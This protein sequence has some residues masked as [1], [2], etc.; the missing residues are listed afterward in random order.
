M[1]ADL[2]AAP[3]AAARP[4]LPRSWPVWVASLLAMAL[5][6]AVPRPAAAQS[7]VPVLPRKAALGAQLSELQ[8]GVRIDAVVPNLTA[9]ALGLQVGDV[10]NRLNDTTVRTPAEVAAW[11]STQV[12][13]APVRVTG[14]RNRKPL[15][16]SGTLAGRT[17]EVST[18]HQ[19][20]YGQV[21]S[22][23]GWLR[24]IVTAPNAGAAQKHPALMFVQ[25]IGPGTV[26]FALTAD[27]GYAKVIQP[28]ARSGYV[29]MRVDKPGVGDSEGGPFAAVDFQQT[30]DGYRQALKA[31][32]A[33]P[34]VDPER[35]F[36][37]GH[38]MG[39]YWG[40][41]L[42]REFKLKGIVVS[43][44]AFRTWIEY[45]LENTRRQG[46]LGGTTPLDMHNLLQDKALLNSAW[47]LEGLTPEQIVARYPRLKQLVAE[48]FRP[49]PSGPQYSGQHARFWQQVAALN[50]P[51]VWAGA[52]G[53]VLALYGAS[54]FLTD[55]ADHELL[56]SW[57]NGLRPETA[58]FVLLANSD[59]AFLDTPSQRDSLLQWGKP[60]GKV[61]TNILPV[62]NEWVTP[63]SG[64][65]LKL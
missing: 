65:P 42:A 51:E 49:S 60:G 15:R 57:V 34:D 56:V 61:N 45:D 5:Y 20:T 64:V 13:G 41:L 31:L 18:D 37:F 54:D 11:L 59:H 19:V 32:L 17:R 12:E 33:R 36:L 7:D 38:S 14:E 39:G 46:T 1:T 30:L 43:G 44:T 53:H 40:P 23:R 2:I 48:S 21:K 9:Q 25:G 26:D 35:V 52:S 29:T 50:M 63:L 62:L 55:A 10:I 8:I 58:R 3:H 22:E 4:A 16:L 47:L 6:L 27:N 28:F 24:T